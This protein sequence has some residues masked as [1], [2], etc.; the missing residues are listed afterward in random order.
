MRTSLSLR[1]ISALMLFVFMGT[2]ASQA[3]TVAT[4]ADPVPFGSNDYLFQF[5]NDVLSG[6]WQG[7]NLDLITPITA[8][9]YPDATFTMTPLTVDSMGLTSAGTI[10]FHES[11]SMGGDL[12]LQITFDHA[13]LYSPFGFGG[14]TLVIGHNV[15]FSGPIITYPLDEEMFAFSFANQHSNSNGYSWSAAFTSSA[16]PEPCTLGLFGVAFLAI[17]RRR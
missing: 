11:A 15:Q 14:S 3:D 13:Q 8:E 9:I 1:V 7:E 2:V 12:I 6:G 16:I 17:R 4:F 5:A 10:E